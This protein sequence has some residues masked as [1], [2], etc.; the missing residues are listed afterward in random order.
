MTP[1]LGTQAYAHKAQRSQSLTLSDERVPTHLAEG[2][3]SQTPQK[4]RPRALRSG[5]V[6]V[7]FE[8][9]IGHVPRCFYLVQWT[10]EK[11]LHL[12][13]QKYVARI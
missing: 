9:P 13:N 5:D 1:T 3:T 4:N 11:G 10:L 12:E 2:R 6:R 7:F 8:N